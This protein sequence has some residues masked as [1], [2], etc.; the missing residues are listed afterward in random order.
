MEN[1]E[2]RRHHIRR[3]CSC[4]YVPGSNR[5]IRLQCAALPRV[6]AR[7][8]NR[9]EKIRPRTALLREGL[10]KGQPYFVHEEA[11]TRAGVDLRQ[12]FQRTRW[13][14][15]RCVVWFGARKATGRGEGASNLRNKKSSATG[16]TLWSRRSSR[17]ISKPSR[18]PW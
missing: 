14:N 15:G 7:D 5:A 18:R 2:R 11:I 8:P 10:A 3:C 4:L 6:I 13:H 17:S 9:L 1:V 12:T 16:E